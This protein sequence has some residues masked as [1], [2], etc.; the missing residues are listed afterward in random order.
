MTGR[1]AEAAC[2]IGQKAA[3]AVVQAGSMIETWLHLGTVR[4]ESM[5][6]RGMRGCAKRH[7][8]VGGRDSG[9][10]CLFVDMA[11]LVGWATREHGLLEKG[12]EG[13]QQSTAILILA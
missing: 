8:G 7:R 4:L 13:Q 3:L 1:K 10:Q 11:T 5:G 12:H 6:M 2:C 9:M